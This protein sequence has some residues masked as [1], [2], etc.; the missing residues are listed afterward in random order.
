MRIGVV[1]ALSP[2]LSRESPNDYRRACVFYSFAIKPFFAF[3]LSYRNAYPFFHA[4]LNNQA[5]DIIR[6]YLK[7]EHAGTDETIL[8]AVMFSMLAFLVIMP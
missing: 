3:A 7:P 1:S 5:Y 8:A 4:M 6:L 2:I